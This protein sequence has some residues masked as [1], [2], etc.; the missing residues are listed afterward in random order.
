MEI[1]YGVPAYHMSVILNNPKH[2]QFWIDLAFDGIA[3]EKADW[4]QLFRGFAATTDLPSAHYFEYIAAAFPD[5]KVVLTV[6]D[7]Q[8]WFESY[9]RLMKAVHSFRFIRFLPPL[10]RLW[11]YG[12]RMI[13]FH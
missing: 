2:F 4:Q 11:P 9:R 8:E 3:P 12:Q 5:A 13:P 10:N 6:R 1:L 7:E